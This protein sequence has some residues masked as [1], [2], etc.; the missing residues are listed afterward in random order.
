MLVWVEFSFGAR[1][2]RRAEVRPQNSKGGVEVY[3]VFGAEAFVFN[4]GSLG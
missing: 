2:K 3:C 4:F 1:R